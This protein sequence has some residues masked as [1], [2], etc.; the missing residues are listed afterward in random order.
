M[1]V[2]L[3]PVFFQRFFFLYTLGF[4]CSLSVL[5]LPPLLPVSPPAQS[6]TTPRTHG[7]KFSLPRAQKSKLTL[8]W[9][10]AVCFLSVAQPPPSTARLSLVCPITTTKN[11][12]PPPTIHQR[13]NP[14]TP[15]SGGSSSLPSPSSPFNGSGGRI[16]QSI[17]HSRNALLLSHTA[18]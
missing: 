16:N 6:T 5:P 3:L 14:A 11:P 12:R 1:C 13:P 9:C 7:I 15:R 10:G 8:R 18:R 2:L 17:N 4:A